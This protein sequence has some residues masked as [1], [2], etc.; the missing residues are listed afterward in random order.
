[1]YAPMLIPF[2]S[3]GAGILFSFLTDNIWLGA[4]SII[5]GSLLYLWLLGQR[6]DPVKNFRVAPLHFYWIAFWFFGIGLI[7]GVITAP[8]CPSFEEMKRGKVVEGE[9]TGIRNS[10][11]GD[12]LKIDVS[13]IYFDPQKAESFTNFRLICHSDAV[14]FKEGD[15]ILFPL[16]NLK[17]IED[18]KNTFIKGYADR[19][20]KKG[21]FYQSSISNKDI[22]LIGKNNSVLLLSHRIRDK[23]VD[24]LE[25]LPLKKETRNFIITVLA[26]DTAYLDSKE[27]K[28]FSDAGVA[29]ILALSGMHIGIITGIFL[30]ILFPIE[31]TGRYKLRYALTAIILWVYAFIT[32][33]S[34]TIVRACIMASAFIIAIIIERKNSSLNSLALAGF[35]ILLFS[36][37]A[38]LDVGFQL[39]FVCVASLIIFAT[40]LNPID[41]RYHPTL[42]KICS[43]IL[44]TLIATFSSWIIVAHYFC[45]F[46]IMFLPANIMVVP[47]LPAYITII[48]FYLFLNCIGV[49]P[50]FLT[51]L[52]D[53]IYEGISTIIKIL[54]HDT[55]INLNVPGTSILL[56]FL[57][58]VLLGFAFHGKW[59]RVA[60]WASSA[61]FLTSLILCIYSDTGPTGLLICKS[62][63]NVEM[64][65][66]QRNEENLFRVPLNAISF[67][68]HKN[69]SIMVIDYKDFL[70]SIPK[71]FTSPDIVILTGRFQ[72]SIRDVINKIRT[73]L[74]VIHPSAKR[75]TEDK[76]I[77]EA[78]E[79]NI[80]VHS[81]RH[82]DALE[83]LKD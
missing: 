24:R 73:S 62:Y 79:L 76:W 57:G 68:Q 21:F 20:A 56:W 11:T 26:G 23:F 44:V 17:R 1:M 27:R 46:P 78:E 81:L 22:N 39:S 31:F 53:N 41:K 38:I 6:K 47:L 58:L 70:D 48:L 18:S 32:G 10:T 74:I 50:G 75:K 5:I 4:G 9:I 69:N 30:F 59:R 2:L 12:E 65:I 33:L 82:D 83:I 77:K 42:H 45:S 63:Q 25:K 66:F 7:E 52:V 71:D 49:T 28:I 61:T 43:V 19:M 72:G 40:P 36:P 37:R 16:N 55:V 34:P 13:K 60:F 14:S 15:R 8:Q 64:K 3:L 54:G 80:K 35:I 51:N 67:H 29:H